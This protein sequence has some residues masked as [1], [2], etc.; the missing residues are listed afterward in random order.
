M[1]NV[2]TGL[3]LTFFEHKHKRSPQTG[4]LLDKIYVT[5]VNWPPLVENLRFGMWELND[6]YGR[7]LLACNLLWSYVQNKIESEQIDLFLRWVVY[8]L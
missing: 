8:W 5:Q 6:R 7:K 3:M 1:V 4:E 2:G